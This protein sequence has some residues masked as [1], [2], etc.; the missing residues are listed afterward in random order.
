MLREVLPVQDCRFLRLV[1]AF[2]D[3]FCGSVALPAYNR[4]CGNC[5]LHIE[6][7][8]YTYVVNEAANI[9]EIRDLLARIARATN[10]RPGSKTQMRCRTTC[11]KNT[12]G[13]FTA[14]S[15]GP[16]I[17]VTLLGVPGRIVQQRCQECAR[18][19]AQRLFL[20]QW[21]YFQPQ[22]RMHTRPHQQAKMATKAPSHPAP[23]HKPL[24]PSASFPFFVA[25]GWRAG[26]PVE[27]T[28]T[29]CFLG[30]VTCSKEHKTGQ[31]VSL[32][33][34]GGQTRLCQ[35]HTPVPL[36]LLS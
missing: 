20:A 7:G 5:L 10:A 25:G 9:Q 6:E 19:S 33:V 22:N 12:P 30:N 14:F 3:S 15:T 31:T 26:L 17:Y 18:R 32:E 16:Y 11:R 34:R 21:C 23:N 24:S 13:R 4:A 8:Q 28:P 35:T 29:F 2:V 27:S 1:S 36:A